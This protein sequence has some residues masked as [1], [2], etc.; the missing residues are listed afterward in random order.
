MTDNLAECTIVHIGGG[1]MG[2]GDSVSEGRKN[3]FAG[4]TNSMTNETRLIEYKDQAQPPKYL[5]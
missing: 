2:T 3:V 4:K 5:L 1:R